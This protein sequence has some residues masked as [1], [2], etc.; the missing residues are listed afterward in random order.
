MFCCCIEAR[1]KLLEK[2]CLDALTLASYYCEC[3]AIAQKK[4]KFILQAKITSTKKQKKIM[5]FS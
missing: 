5:N 1:K 3:L 2:I 4:M